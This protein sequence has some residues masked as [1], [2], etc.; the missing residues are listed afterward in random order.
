MP[1]ARPHAFAGTLPQMMR[2]EHSLPHGCR[3][4]APASARLRTLPHASARF[5]T[6][7]HAPARSRTHPHASEALGGHAERPL[8]RHVPP[9]GLPGCRPGLPPGFAARVC[10]P[11]CRPGLLPDG[12]AGRTARL[13]AL[14][15]SGACSPLPPLL[16]GWAGRGGVLATC[17]FDSSIRLWRVDDCGGGGGGGAPVVVSASLAVLC[18][19]LADPDDSPHVRAPNPAQAHLANPTR[20]AW[21]AAACLPG[22][23]ARDR[24][25]CTLATQPSA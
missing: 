13:A 19:P 20:R 11:G 5:R 15:L 22:P 24:G 9:P 6:L 16:L 3:A 14:V 23:S 25:G 21:A 4:L 12:F 18:E 17:S 1:L 8:S 7:P 2:S 10:G